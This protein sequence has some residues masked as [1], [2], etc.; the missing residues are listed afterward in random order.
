MAHPITISIIAPVYRVEKYIGRFVDSV[1]SQSY[2]HIQFIFVNDGTDDSSMEILNSLIQDRYL[3]LQES[4]VIVNQP[5]K[6]LPAARKIGVEYATG[7]YIWHVDSDD[8]LEENAVGRIAGCAVRTEADVIY[9]DFY[10]EYANRTALK[11][12]RDYDSLHKSLYMRRMCNHKAYGCVWNKCVS[13]R[14]YEENTVYFPE[15]PHAE[16]IFLMSQ[17]VGYAGSI[18]HLNEALYHYRKDNPDALTRQKTKM[19]RK[20][21]IRN[22]LALCELYKDKAYNPISPLMDDIFFRAGKYSALYGDVLLEEYPYLADKILNARIRGGAG[23]PVT[24]QIL[25]KMYAWI[26]CKNKGLFSPSV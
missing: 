20:G 7:D 18:V 17:L 2:P 22:Y 24:S 25:L 4:I 1:L 6:G 12:E 19:K 8:W 9:F 26:Y 23:M 10:K 16:D 5:H 14:L 21:M 3:H 11:V 15:Y 13:R